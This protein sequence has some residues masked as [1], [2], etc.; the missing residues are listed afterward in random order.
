MIKLST[1]KGYIFTFYL[2]L[3][4]ITGGVLPIDENESKNYIK[5]FFLISSFLILYF[6]RKE[7]ILK[8]NMIF[9]LI[10]SILFFISMFSSIDIYY[11]LLKWDGAILSTFFIVNILYIYL[12]KYSLYELSNYFIKSM[13]ILLFVTV[14]YKINYGF[15]DRNIRFFLNGAN[16]FGWLMGYSALFSLLAYFSYKMPKYLI[17]LVCFFLALIW[18][19]SKGALLGTLLCFSFFL[20]FKSK[21]L[22]KFISILIFMALISF[23]E[24]IFNFLILSFPDSRLIAIIRILNSDVEEVDNGSVSVRSF[25]LKEGLQLFSQHPFQGVG[26]GN[27]KFLTIYGFDYIHNINFEVF[28]ECGLIVG[29]I[30]LLFVFFGLIRANYFIRLT[31]IF[32]LITASFS[33]DISYLHFILIPIVFSLFYY[34]NPNRLEYIK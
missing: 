6:F 13:L 30:Y 24:I 33:G 19:Q 7:K 16:V 4:I 12:K 10:S 23:K 8:I 15:F 11:A 27:Y 31:I 2:L 5:I 14:L 34:L 22:T 26:L 9:F 25:M 32:F 3:F 1:L 18:T 29:F 21:V 20:I 28:L 17:A